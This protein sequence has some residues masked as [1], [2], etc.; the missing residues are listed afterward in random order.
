MFDDKI[1]VIAEAGIN[2]NGKINLAFELAD[3]ALKAGANAIK[4]QIF[5]TKNLVKKNLKTVS[6]QRKGTLGVSNQYEMLK[7]LELSKKHFYSLKKYCD[8]IGIEFMATPFDCES[9]KFLIDLNIRNIKISSGEITNGPLIWKAAKS[10]S[11]LIISTGMANQ[12]E[13]R[14][15][16]S[17]ILHSLENTNEP[18]S[19]KEI[20]KLNKKSKNFKNLQN[21]V[22]LLHCTSQYPTPLKNINLNVLKSLKNRYGLKVGLSDH[23]EGTLVA[24][25]SIALGAR[26]IEK[27]ITLDKN[28]LGPDHSSSIE[29]KEFKDMVINMKKIYDTLGSKKIKKLK[30]ENEIE[31][32]T[33]QRIIAIKDIPKGKKINKSD[34]GTIRSSKGKVGNFIWDHIGKISE[35][36]F[37]SGQVIK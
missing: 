27:H 33:R 13:I 30:I 10:N 7:S 15:C 20:L 34:L 28:M 36:N 21:K 12:K 5:D 6:Y 35:K 32:K 14:L 17:T 16:L 9:L 23:S 37:K 18:R 1:F 2:H 19:L 3:Q 25:V 31:K 29:P 24:P 11:S 4:F 26:I 8:D 22:S